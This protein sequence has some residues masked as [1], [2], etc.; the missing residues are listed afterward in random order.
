M[1][2]RSAAVSAAVAVAREHGVRVLEPVV[3]NDS[4]NLRILLRPAPV[5]A[6]V[7]TTTA[8]GR[9]DPAEAL[10]REVAVVSYLHGAGAP[11]V[12]PSEL[13]PPGPHRRDGV[14]MSFWAH[15]RHDPGQAVPPEVAGRMLAELHEALRGFPCELPRLGP[16]LDEPARLLDLLAR[17]GSRLVGD[18]ELAR[19]REAHAT[20]AQRL[21]GPV[22]AVHGDAHPGNL[23]ATPGGLLWND[24][25]ECMAAPVEWDLACLLRTTRLDG[26][27]AVRAYG[28]DPDGP[29]LRAFLAARGL[30]GTLWV[31]ARALRFPDQADR[32]RAVLRTWLDDPSGATR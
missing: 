11:V 8:L 28:A 7:P 17:P 25:E 27:A 1:I 22:R 19:L 9:P 21:G 30:Q 13:L 5:V 23:L 14:A 6:R 32:A 16:V 29:G 4:F 3:L 2:S 10:G 12:P 20:L 31:L 15:V 26:R 18:G 24:F